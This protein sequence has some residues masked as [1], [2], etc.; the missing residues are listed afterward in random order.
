MAGGRALESR[1]QGTYLQTMAEKQKERAA[2]V[3][4][5]ISIQCQIFYELSDLNSSLQF[6]EAYHHHLEAESNLLH[7]AACRW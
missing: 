3:S 1:S 7:P 2:Q 5:T 4:I 6:V